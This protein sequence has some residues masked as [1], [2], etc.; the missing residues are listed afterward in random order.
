MPYFVFALA[1][2]VLWTFFAFIAASFVL[3]ALATALGGAY[4]AGHYLLGWR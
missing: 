1:G 3:I 2:M 4:L